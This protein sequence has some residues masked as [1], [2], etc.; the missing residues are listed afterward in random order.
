MGDI[1]P[2]A[3]AKF[4]DQPASARHRDL[5]DNAVE[6]LC[7]W[8]KPSMSATFLEVAGVLRRPPPGARLP[9]TLAP[10]DRIALPIRDSIGRYT[11]NAGVGSLVVEAPFF[12]AK[13]EPE[14]S[15]TA[16]K[17]FCVAAAHH[18]RWAGAIR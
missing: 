17:P 13:I 6:N 15:A 3:P 10:P 9:S 7:F 16:F 4:A 2:V 5:L 8:R 14:W 1:T 11:V 12:V 18:A